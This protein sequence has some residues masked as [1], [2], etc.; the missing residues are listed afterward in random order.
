MTL[1]KVFLSLIA[2]ES[3][4]NSN[5]Y[6]FVV[7]LLYSMTYVSFKSIHTEKYIIP[8]IACGAMVCAFIV[9]FWYF[10]I[11]PTYWYDTALCY[12]LGMLYS[13]AKEKIHKIVDRHWSIWWVGVIAVLAM[14]VLLKI[15]SAGA[16]TSY[17]YE[18]YLLSDKYKAKLK[19]LKKYEK[20]KQ[21]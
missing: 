20:M 14:L 18:K 5:W 21:Q 16:I 12:I 9:G 17:Q 3:V 15:F 1:P 11:K 19:R 8:V 13:L 7:L 10:D 2:W 6:I 4:G